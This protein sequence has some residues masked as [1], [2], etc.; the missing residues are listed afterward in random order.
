MD[1][2]IIPKA[3][4]A[5]ATGQSL[6]QFAMEHDIDVGNLNR[7][8]RKHDPDGYKLARELQA[9]RYA[10]DIIEIADTEPDAQKARNRIEARKWLAGCQNKA[11]APKQEGQ[12]DL[13]GLS[14]SLNLTRPAIE[15]TPAI[16]EIEHDKE[17]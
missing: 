10:E 11:Y 9:D 14:I 5:I 16:E 6:R 17:R 7:F 2:D 1:L 8:I 4:E 15:V 13:Q 12:I 3:L